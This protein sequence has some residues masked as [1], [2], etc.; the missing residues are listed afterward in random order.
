MAY[1]AIDNPELYFQTKLYAG[2]GSTLSV[3]YDGEEDM[4]ANMIWLKSRSGTTNHHIFDTV[5]GVNKYLQANVTNVEGSA[6]TMTTFGSD[7][8]TVSSDSSVN[9]SSST[10]VAWNWKAGTSLSNSADTNGG[11]IAT[12]GSINTTSGFGIVKYE[13]SGANATIYHGLTKIPRLILT[14]NIDQTFNWSVYAFNSNTTILRLNDVTA[15]A[16]ESAFQ[17]T[18]P[19]ATV[20]SLGDHNENNGA[21]DGSAD[22]HVSYMFCDVQGFQKIGVYVGNNNVSGPFIYTGFRPAMVVVHR[23]DSG[24]SWVIGNNKALGYNPDTN[25][26]LWDT[27]TA[28]STT[29]WINFYSNGFQLIRTDASVNASGGDYLYYAV[30]EAPFVN[31]NGVPNNAR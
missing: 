25:F 27:T 30:A 21:T 11:S 24:D 3:T 12:T 6:S 19:T 31:S 16:T 8:F 1:T 26:S 15:P 13:G 17:S 14:K 9:A 5:R 7:G 10:N 23:F 29:D 22:T 2:T 18:D 4:S 28:E 20:Q